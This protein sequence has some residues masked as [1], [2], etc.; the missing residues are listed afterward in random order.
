MK[1]T[2]LLI[3]AAV[4]VALLP[5]QTFAQG[6][7]TTVVGSKEKNNYRYNSTTSFNGKKYILIK[8]K[9]ATSS[10][11]NVTEV[12]V[13][14]SILDVIF[15]QSSNKQT[16]ADVYFKEVYVSDPSYRIYVKQNGSVLDIYQ[17]PKT[18][19][20]FTKS[21]GSIT[22]Y[23]PKDVK[24]VSASVV[25]GDVQ[26]KG[27][28]LD[29][30]DLRSIS[31][32]ADV[33]NSNIS[34]VSLKTTSGD[35][36]M[37]QSVFG[38]MSVSSISGDVEAKDVK[39]DFFSAKTTSGDIEAQY[40]K[41]EKID[42]SSISGDVEVKN[43][44]PSMLKT[45]TTSGDVTAF[46]S[47]VKEASCSS[48]SGNVT[49]YVKGDLKKNSYYFSSVSGDLEVEGYVSTRRKLEMEGNGGASITAKTTSGDVTVKK[50]Q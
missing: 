39:T 23:V 37:L 28:T 36:D 21:S 38:D 27:L 44:T 45:R 33:Y 42:V 5:E 2:L 9:S 35:V 31:G 43:S 14:Q 18:G 10:Y 15:V 3:A 49:L 40:I 48:V 17:E 34:N 30:A 47:E 13:D 19:L 11:Q 12:R 46:V 26:V 41:S 29:K 4:F 16:R 1:K 22:I 7:Q 6:S 20:S 24:V 25:S 50:W 8:E 32:D